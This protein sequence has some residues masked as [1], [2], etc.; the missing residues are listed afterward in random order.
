MLT[1]EV[2]LFSSRVLLRYISNDKGTRK[3]EKKGKKKI[4]VAHSLFAPFD[5][6]ARVRKSPCV[7]QISRGADSRARAVIYQ[8][9]H[10][11]FT[12]VHA[13]QLSELS[14]SRFNASIRLRVYI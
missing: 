3:K 11:G 7:W 2:G 5:R 6:V 4:P 13:T 10:T 14:A 12:R 8:A 9:V 1:N